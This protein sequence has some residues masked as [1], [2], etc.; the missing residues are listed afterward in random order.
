MKLLSRAKGKKVRGVAGVL[1]VTGLSLISQSNAVRRGGDD[2]GVKQAV[3]LALVDLPV[4]RN[5]KRLHV[6]HCL[7]HPTR[8][9]FISWQRLWE[10]SRKL[11]AHIDNENKRIS[12]TAKCVLATRTGVS[13]FHM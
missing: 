1:I 6:F 13:I 5:V 10:V 7:Q 2:D 8:A 3:E 11:K 12:T 9:R 4:P